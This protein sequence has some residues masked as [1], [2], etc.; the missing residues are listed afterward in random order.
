MRTLIGGLLMCGL[1]QGEHRVLVGAQM[2][3][4]GEGE[5]GAGFRDGNDRDYL[6]QRYRFSMDI[7][8]VAG[9][10]FYG[11]VQDARVAWLPEAGNSVKDRLDLRQA[12]AGLGS[13]SKLWDLRVG[14]QKMAFGSERVIGAGEWGNTARVFDAGRLALHRG[15]DRVD[16]F[17]S[18]VVVADVDHW[19]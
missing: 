16:V 4:R 1:A 3:L 18:S 19:D 14:R 2:R 15:K 5:R 12:W 9:L 8:P 17:A 7:R 10:E 13:E 6:L 11:E